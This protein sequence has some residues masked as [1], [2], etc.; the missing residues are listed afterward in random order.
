M[1]E[2]LRL[3]LDQGLTVGEVVKGSGL[4]RP[5]LRSIEEDET[6]FSRAQTLK[7]LADFYGVR[8]S[9]LRQKNTMR[10]Y[11]RSGDVIPEGVTAF[12]V[13]DREL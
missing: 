9:T 13:K 1:F 4:T 12:V 11:L 2:A 8:A 3:R 7:K 6:Y 10:T 5:T